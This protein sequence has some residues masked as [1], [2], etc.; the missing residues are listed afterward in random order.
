MNIRMLFCLVASTLIGAVFPVVSHAQLLSGATVLQADLEANDIVYDRFRDVIYATVG[1]DLG[2]PNGNSILTLD[3]NTLSV[4]DQVS[5]GSEPNQ[6][7]ISN[8]GS[9]V[10]VGINGARSVRSF[11]PETGDRGDLHFIETVSPFGNPANRGDPA[12]AEDL[13]VSS[14]S[15]DRV[16]VSVNNTGSSASGELQLF[17]DGVG[18]VGNVL[19]FADANSLAFLDRDTLITYENRST[20][21]A[22]SRFAFDGSNF[23]FL[24]SI[25]GLVRG[26]GTQIESS[27]GLIFGTDGTVVDPD[28]SFMSLGSFSGSRG[29]RKQRVRPNDLFFE[30]R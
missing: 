10:Y 26:F 30:K 14:F 1:S 23:T 15:P 29:V 11:S 27:G 28:T 8:D 17:E 12:V 4:I 24:G 3:P 16:I 25:G 20:G 2:F 6:L 21:F 7:T 18:R 13:I 9:R 22:L 5:I 19:P